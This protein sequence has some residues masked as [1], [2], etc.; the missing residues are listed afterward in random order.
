MDELHQGHMVVH[1]GDGGTP[2]TGPALFCPAVRAESS[3]VF[4]RSLR[5]IQRAC[6]LTILWSSVRPGSLKFCRRAAN[7][8]VLRAGI[9]IL[10]STLLHAQTTTPDSPGRSGRQ[11]ESQEGQKSPASSSEA[12]RSQNVLYQQAQAASQKAVTLR[13]KQTRADLS[14]A[15]GLYRKSARL[16]EAAHLYDNAAEAHL[17]AAEIY[18][19]VSKYDEAWRA[20]QQALKLAQNPE[21]R[22]TALSRIARTY[23]NIGPSSLADNYSSQA[24]TLCESLSEKAQAEAQEARG[25]ALE[26]AGEHSRSLAYLAR[27]H[28]LFAAVRDD[29]GEAQALLMLA[30]ALFA[31]GKR[32][33]SLKAA[34]D[35]LRLWSSAADR[36]G[37]AH[38]HAALGAFAI[39]TGEFETAQCNFRL[40]RPLFHEIGSRDDEATT[41]N[42]MGWVNREMGDWQKSLESYRSA[43]AE[44]ASVRDL[45]GEQ[46]AV[47][48]EGM[49]LAAMKEYKRLL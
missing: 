13:G 6:G 35:A 10:F 34:G 33:Q 14:A 40:A 28:D 25:E 26:F 49:V 38:V 29:N 41:L 39:T 45:I 4:M 31:D 22:C 27:A 46:Q 36:S 12:G 30:Y 15:I 24:L 17:Q 21:L 19:T 47:A 3:S 23:A 44:F 42:G 5:Q 43:K 48:G 7:S 18:F 37:I 32:T 8:L 1:P 16:F 9:L 2:G 20:N 11:A